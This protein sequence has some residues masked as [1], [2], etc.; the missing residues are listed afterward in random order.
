[1]K[2]VLGWRV[3]GCMAVALTAGL[4]LT[5]NAQAPAKGTPAP[6]LTPAPEALSVEFA[7]RIPPVDQENLQSYR[8]A[9]ESRTKE[10]WLQALPALAKPPQSTPGIVTIT[11]WVHTD[12]RVTGMAIEKPSGKA[13]L[14]RAASGAITG[15]SPYDAFPYGIAVDEV[16]M[17]FTFTYNGGVANNPAPVNP[18][19]KRK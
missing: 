2:R 5:V 13:A 3:P 15:S 6:G 9:L 4:V 12:G 16:R 17:R 7:N 8:T 11:C 18:D 1:M 10:R 14:D 19:R